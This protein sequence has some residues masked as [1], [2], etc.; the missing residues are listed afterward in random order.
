VLCALSVLERDVDEANR[1]LGEALVDGQ[2]EW[3]IRT[4][5]EVGPAVHKLLVSCTPSVGQEDYVATLLAA[6]SRDVAPVRATASATLIDPL[7]PREVTV[8]RYLCSRL[9]YSEIAAALF[10]SLNTLKSHVRTVYRK[11][12]VASRADAVETG[13]RL[14]VI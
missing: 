2:A 5:I 3:L 12:G 14:G 9:T 13:R 7:S 11:L 10:V 1:H 8:L 4:V 6:V